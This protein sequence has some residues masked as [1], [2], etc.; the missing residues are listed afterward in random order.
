MVDSDGSVIY[1]KDAF[2]DKK[3]L[4]SIKGRGNSTW[5]NGVKKPYQI[6]LSSKADL[7]GTD[8]PA[9]KWIL[10]A[11]SA[12]ATLLHSSVAFNLAAELGLA[13]VDVRPIDLYYDGEYRGS[14]LLAEKIEIK[15][16]RVDIFDLEEAIENANL[17]TGPRCAAH[18]D[19]DEQIRQRVPVRRGRQGSLQHRGRL[20]ARA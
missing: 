15:P 19:S 9:K 17:G 6:S 14:Y 11:N 2:G 13:T 3:T 4:S 16:G 7:I 18:Q 12:D 20:S 1:D 10:L 5:G 8:A